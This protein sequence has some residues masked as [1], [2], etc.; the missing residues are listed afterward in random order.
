MLAH[1]YAFDTVQMPLN[2]F[3]ANFR[4]FEKAVLP[5]LVRRGI[6]CLGMKPLTGKGAPIKANLVTPKEMLSYAMSLPGVAVTIT[7]L[8]S[9]DRAK[10]NVEIARGFKALDEKALRAIRDKCAGTAADKRYELYNVSLKYDN[11]EARR[12]HGFPIDSEQMEVKE[13]LDYAAGKGSAK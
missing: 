4:S 7:G 9:V 13:L 10:Q 12:A 5:E 11:P 2:C 6:G 3:D 1:G 8:E